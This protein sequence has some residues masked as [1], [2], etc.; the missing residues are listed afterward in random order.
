MKILLSDKSTEDLIVLHKALTRLGITTDIDIG[1]LVSFER[2]IEGYYHYVVVDLN[3]S[4]VNCYRLLYHIKSNNLKTKIIFLSN[5]ERKKTDF[6]ETFCI[7][8]TKPLD[9][10]NLVAL[11]REEKV[12]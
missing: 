3:Q 9:I 2:L 12:S 6:D 5:F 4:D 10:E 1:S 7:F 8:Y 11:M